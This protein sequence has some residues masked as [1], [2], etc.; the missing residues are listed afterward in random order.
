MT[1]LSFVKEAVSSSVAAWRQFV[2][3]L[4]WDRMKGDDPPWGRPTHFLPSLVHVADISAATQMRSWDMVPECET[5]WSPLRFGPPGRRRVR[6][7][8]NARRC[9]AIITA[10]AGRSS[11]NSVSYPPSPRCHQH[12]VTSAQRPPRRSSALLMHLLDLQYWAQ[13][14]SVQAKEAPLHPTAL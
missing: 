14:G 5:D 6:D 13:L 1:H 11:R 12:F 7:P 9:L 2:T 10:S 8:P 3:V 4:S